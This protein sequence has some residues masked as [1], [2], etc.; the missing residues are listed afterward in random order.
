MTVAHRALYSDGRTAARHEVSFVVAGDRLRLLALDGAPLDEWPLA[1]IGWLEEVA[2]GAPLRLRRGDARLT[3]AHPA[4]QAALAA[5]LPD[6]PG[7]EGRRG[8]VF[9]WVAGSLVGLALTVGAAVAAWPTLERFLLSLVPA[10]WEVALGEEV[11]E[12]LLGTGSRLFQGRPADICTGGAGREAVA[13]LVDRL[14][15]GTDRSYAMTVR[16]VDSDMVNALA[17]P[18]GQILVFRGLIDEAE[19]PSELAGVLAHE[20]AHVTHRHGLTALMR[21]QGLNLLISVVTGG[22]DAGALLGNSAGLLLTLGFGRA[23]EAEADSTAIGLLRGAGIRADGA[24]RFFERVAKEAGSTPALLQTHPAPAGRAAR[25]AAEGPAGGPGLSDAQ[26][27]A[28]R[29][30]CERTEPYGAD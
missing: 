30:I 23:A 14:A 24:A 9:R 17:A 10:S 19:D 8:A 27:A 5:A 29:G 4:A 1:E 18:G 21:S 7:P 3:V 16:V 12:S 11:V 13:A 20:M 6:A 15:A 2:P 25:F 26:W 22:S 28:V